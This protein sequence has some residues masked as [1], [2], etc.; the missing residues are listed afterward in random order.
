MRVLSTILV[1]AL[2]GVL[3]GAAIAYVEIRSDPDAIDALSDE[4]AE[5]AKSGGTESSHIVVDGPNYNFGSMQRGTTKSHEFVIHNTGTAPLTIRNAGTTCKCTLSK[6]AEES[7]A[8][9]GSTSVKLEWT[10]KVDHGPFQQTA[11]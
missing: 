2:V 5:K 6:V 4:L 9:G 11:T 8:P 7:I 10:A 1:A 3:G